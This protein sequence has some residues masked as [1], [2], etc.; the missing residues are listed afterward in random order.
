[1]MPDWKVIMV[2][3]SASHDTKAV[4]AEQFEKWHKAKGWKDIGYHWIIEKIGDRYHSIMGR[5]M[6]M[7]GSHSTGMNSKALGVVF[8]GNFQESRVPQEQLEEGADLIAGLCFG[9]GIGSSE[10][11]AHRDFR[12]TLCP[13]E[14]FPMARLR[15]MVNDRLSV[16]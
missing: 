4:D 2:H 16:E 14:L 11:V 3:H 1:M 5:P 15:D 7:Q 9:L 8:A 6:Y 12:Q 10:V 13:G